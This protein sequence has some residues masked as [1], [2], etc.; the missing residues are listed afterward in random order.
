MTQHDGKI[1]AQAQSSAPR[2]VPLRFWPK[3]EWEKNQRIWRRYR[4]TIAKMRERER[5]WQPQD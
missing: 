2:Y 1:K 3:E 4:E 5:C